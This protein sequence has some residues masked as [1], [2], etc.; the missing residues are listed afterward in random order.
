MIFLEHAGVRFWRVLGVPLLALL[1]MLPLNAC[2]ADQSARLSGAV[3][4]AKA[5]AQTDAFLTTPGTGYVQAYVR[6]GPD[7]GDD[8]IMFVDQELLEG[9]TSPPRWVSGGDWMALVGVQR[10]GAV[11]VGGGSQ[12]TLKGEPSSDR[13]WVIHDLRQRLQPDIWYRLRVEADFAQRHF[14]SFTIDGGDLSRTLDLSEVPLDY[15]N[16]MPFDK[17]GLIYIVGA[18]RSRAM[19]KR[20]GVPL[21]YFDDVEGGVV[22]PNG[23]TQRLFSDSFEAQTVVG[24]QPVTSPTISLNRYTLGQWYLERDESVFRIENASFART[25]SKVGVAD[26]TLPD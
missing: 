2:T 9:V 15:P 3:A 12:Q 4:F 1:A 11:W 25:G 5:T 23:T 6:F 13:A 16:Y 19:M 7:L 21:V 22:L 20:V 8:V 26:T 17:K 10:S 18:M 24:R 14:I